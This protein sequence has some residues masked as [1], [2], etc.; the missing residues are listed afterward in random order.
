MR[1]VEAAQG[2]RRPAKSDVLPAIDSNMTN[3]LTERRRVDLVGVAID[4]TGNTRGVELICSAAA[5]PESGCGTFSFGVE[6]AISLLAIDLNTTDGA[7]T[8]SQGVGEH[9]L[10][11]RGRGGV[12]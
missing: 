9:R 1:R 10:L 7:G 4:R 12:R 6:I 11:R 5:K 8:R 3:A 2:E